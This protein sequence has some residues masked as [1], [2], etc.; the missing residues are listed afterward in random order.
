[1]LTTPQSSAIPTTTVHGSSAVKGSMGRSSRN[2]P[3]MSTRTTTFWSRVAQSS[4]RAAEMSFEMRSSA[5][6]ASA[7]SE[8][9]RALMG[10]RSST[11]W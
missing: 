6:P 2:T 7:M 5:P 8:S 9:A 3:A 1:M 11:V 4:D 10:E